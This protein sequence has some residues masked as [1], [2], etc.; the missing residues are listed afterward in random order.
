M[1][2]VH[3]L[4]QFRGTFNTITWAETVCQTLNEEYFRDV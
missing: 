3:R 2:D 1:T 4:I